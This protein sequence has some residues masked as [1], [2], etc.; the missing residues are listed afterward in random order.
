MNPMIK[1][2]FTLPT[3]ALRGLVVFPDMTLHFD[4]GRKAS[5]SAVKNAMVTK[6]NIFLVTQTDMSEEV[7]AEDGLF[8]TG[9]VCAI[10][11]LVRLP[12]GDYFRV[13]VEGKYRAKL[14]E[15]CEKK[16]HF[17]ARIR[18]LTDKDSQTITEAER[19]A[20]LRY[21]KSLF[22]EYAML[23]K[24][25]APDIAVGIAG[26]QAAGELADYI[27]GN[28]PLEFMDKQ[29]ILEELNVM[30]RLE[31]LCVVLM[32]EIEML[33]TID[34]IDA[35]VQDQIDENQREYYLR[36]QMKAISQE[37][38]D[39][40][41]SLGEA[42]KYQAQILQLHLEKDV[43]EKLLQECDRMARMQPASPESTVLRTYLDTVL[44]L[45]WGKYTKDNLRLSNARKILDADHFGLNEVK[46][47]I[48]ELLAVRK[49]SPDIKGQILCLA[50]PPGVGK[51]S[52][53]RSLA[54]AMNRKYERIS[55]G[56]VNDES[57]IRGHR[58]T[59]IGAM[60]GSLTTALTRAGSANPLILLDEIDKLSRDYKGDPASAL[61][62]ALDPEQNNAFRD[63][64][65][66][67]PFDLSKVLFVTTANDVSSIPA[68]LLDRMEVIE[69]FSYTSEEK[70][71]IAKKHLV[72]KQLHENGLK[73]TQLRITDDA[74]RLMIDG[75][76]RE[77]GVRK[78]ERTIAKVMRKAAMKIADGYTK[79]ITIRPADLD[80]MLGARKY[81]PEVLAE[82]DAVGSVNGLAWTSVGG[83]LLKVEAVA[84]D[85]T[86]KLELTGSLGDVMKES[87]K[88]ACSYIR[89]HAP[90]WNIDPD[91]YKNKDIH[92]HFPE[93]AVPKDGPSAGVTVTTAVASALSGSPVRA[94]VAMTGEVTL[95]GQVLPI[96]GL[97]EKTMAAYK[98]GIRTVLIPKENVPDLREIDPTVA[99]ALEFVAVSDVADLLSRV[100]LPIAEKEPSRN[101]VK[102]EMPILQPTS[103]TTQDFWRQS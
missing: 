92:I 48:L 49:L 21:T 100:L 4:V 7:A 96:G 53:A 70:F 57:E 35:R 93:G 44:A 11:Q 80:E 51:T 31:K 95:T 97:R 13:V 76:T 5:I 26:R 19:E 90:A 52:I 101:H 41:S 103:A 45:P 38:G 58:K 24:K 61:L 34:D 55:L 16:P 64:Y 23:N 43:E 94:D 50:G 84:M 22:E 62:E 67:V 17:V 14:L 56:G 74:L 78:L 39:G 46:E 29:Q 85:G 65:I 83:T 33:D 10:K 68:P 86:G 42:Q 40:E 28:I 30:K 6:K 8:G 60:P 71:Q 54:R 27:A 69:L 89:C 59:Y 20:M 63:H 12:S 88:A 91:F 75:Y 3:V 36:E 81:K 32:R 1:D 37:L 15:V 66:E 25:L 102:K 82:K 99:N 2:D 9:V 73:S 77:A 72:R 47:R 18:A 79:K 98:S 87:A